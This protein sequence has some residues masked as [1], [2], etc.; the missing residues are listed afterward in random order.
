LDPCSVSLTLL[1]IESTI[2]E[3]EV[4]ALFVKHIREDSRLHLILIPLTTIHESIK[5]STMPMEIDNHLHFSFLLELPNHPLGC[6]KRWIKLFAYLFSASIKI[7]TTQRCSV[8]T[9]N[10]SIGID[11]RHYLKNSMFP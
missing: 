9:M 8:M 1:E 11:H 5:F 7:S 3:G 4:L 2:L 10:N 6:I